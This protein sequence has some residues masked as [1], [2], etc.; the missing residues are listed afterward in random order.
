MH[1]VLRSN[2]EAAFPSITLGDG[3]IAT[4]GRTSTSHVPSTVHTEVRTVLALRT[5][6]G[7]S[8]SALVLGVV[9]C[10]RWSSAR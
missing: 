1:P 10:V 6:L 7:Q 4:W 8:L 5:V 3:T 9:E 2:D